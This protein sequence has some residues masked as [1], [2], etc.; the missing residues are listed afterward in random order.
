MAFQGCCFFRTAPLP[1]VTEA[2]ST[3]PRARP[4]T[5]P[6]ISQRLQ[7]LGS[8]AVNGF[9]LIVADTLTFVGNANVGN[10]VTS[11][12]ANGSLIKDAALV[13]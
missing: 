3:A 9:T 7:L 1:T 2:Q 12:L 11:C 10:N 6:S 13:Q 5:V 8:S 4:S